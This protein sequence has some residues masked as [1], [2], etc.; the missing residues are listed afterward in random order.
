M[1][2]EREPTIFLHRDR[3]TRSKIRL[4]WQDFNSNRLRLIWKPNS[5]EMPRCSSDNK[6]NITKNWLMIRLELKPTRPRLSSRKWSSATN[7]TS[8]LRR[9]VLRASNTWSDSSRLRPSISSSRSSTR[10]SKR[11]VH[12]WMTKC[13]VK[14]NKDWS[15]K[16]K[17]NAWKG[18]S[19][20]LLCVYRTQRCSNKPLTKISKI[21]WITPK[22]WP[23]VNLSSPPKREGASLLLLRVL[24][25]EDD[26]SHT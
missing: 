10:S 8:N 3:E 23:M 18:R 20:S 15:M 1:K 24:E 5:T 12:R 4:R 7:K 9:I 21:L 19:K 11:H 2:Q 17:L 22:W 13:N 6:L 16:K 14:L 26:L 25:D